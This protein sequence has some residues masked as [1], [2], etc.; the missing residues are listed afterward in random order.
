MSG[1]H[2]RFF[3]FC[4]KMCGID[5]TFKFWN[6]FVHRDC[7]AYISLFLAIR[8][9]NWLLRLAAIKTLSPLYH[10][11]DRSTY[12]RLVVKHLADNLIMPSGMLKQLRDRGFS[13]TLTGSMWKQ[14]TLDE[15]HE[16]W[17][18]LDIKTFVYRPNPE[19][20]NNSAAYLT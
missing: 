20:L 13:A 12:L 10:A 8:S 2:H 15:C 4:S 19:Y 17:I 16:S 11:Y 9:W 7:F 1:L 14:L 18:N 6:T 3:E 5:D